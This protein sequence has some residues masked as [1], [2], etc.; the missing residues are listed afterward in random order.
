[1]KVLVGSSCGSLED[2]D[3]LDELLD[4]V[5]EGSWEEA[6]V[7]SDATDSSSPWVRKCFLLGRDGGKE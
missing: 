3:S 5:S 6:A 4:E 7:A 1:M 2:V